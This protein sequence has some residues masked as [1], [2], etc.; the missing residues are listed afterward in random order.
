MVSENVALATIVAPTRH[1]LSARGVRGF[2][3]VLRHAAKKQSDGRS[4][5][6]WCAFGIERRSE[7]ARG[8]RALSSPNPFI[9]VCRKVQQTS[10]GKPVGVLRKVTTAFGVR[11]QKIRIHGNTPLNSPFNFYTA[12][13]T[14][15][16]RGD[17]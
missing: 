10:L 4:D 15:G 13:S 11:F 12:A 16:I 6:F 2:Y 7:K 1:D 8:S 3:L 5:L 14:T 17:A 9:V